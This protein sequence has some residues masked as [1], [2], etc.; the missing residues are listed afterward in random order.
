MRCSANNDGGKNNHNIHL[1]LHFIGLF[2]LS[3]AVCLE[4][5]NNVMVTERPLGQRGEHE[6]TPH[7]LKVFIPRWR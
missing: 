5:S 4:E 3:R 2:H 1:A 7:L 6:L